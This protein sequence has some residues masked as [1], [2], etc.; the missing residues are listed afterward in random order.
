MKRTRDDAHDAPGTDSF[1]DVVCNLVGILIILVMV[2]GI[3]AK[4]AFVAAQSAPPVQ[5]ASHV[6]VDSARQAAKNVEDHINHI[7][8]QIKEVN[9]ELERRTEERNRLQA[10]TMAARE[11]IEELKNNLDGRQR[12]RFEL[13]RQLAAAHHSLRSLEL[14]RDAV[15]AAPKAV[16][17]IEHLPTPM[18]KTV[19]GREEHFRLSGNR[20]TYIPW[21]SLVEK[22]KTEAPEKVW[23]LKEAPRI[24]ESLGPEGG[25]M[26]KY[27]LVRKQYTT[28]TKV[29]VA[30][31]QG[32]ELEKFVLVPVQENLGEPVEEALRPGSQFQSRLSQYDP[33][34]TTLTIW[35]YPD[36][37]DDF[38]TLKQELF[39]R[40]YL[41][42]ARPLPD[43]LPI[44]GSPQGTRSAAE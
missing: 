11:K 16:G 29:G 32:V 38:R 33:Q 19:L 18:A 21:E 40:G 41:T 15:A 2:V 36:S 1:L 44:G 5:A 13:N 20:L 25:F 43:D 27:S 28:P 39:R 30:I 42:A 22:L 23:K 14:E 37:F 3:R 35:V 12:E 4:D 6:D 17:V 8:Q 7:G 24:T 9:G 34:R 26:M 31:R 10:V